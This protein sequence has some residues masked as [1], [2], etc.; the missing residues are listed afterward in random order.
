MKRFALD[1]GMDRIGGFV[2][3]FSVL[4]ARDGDG[5]WSKS[6]F[7]KIMRRLDKGCGTSF[8]CVCRLLMVITLIKKT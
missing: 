5:R 1:D 7:M 2:F 3:V 6:L 4:C 8:I